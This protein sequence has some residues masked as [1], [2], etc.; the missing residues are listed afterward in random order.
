MRKQAA[1]FAFMVA[2]GFVSGVIAQ[3]SNCEFPQS[4][5]FDEFNYEGGQSLKAK[6]K[7]FTASFRQEVSAATAI[8]YVY[9][10]RSSKMTEISDLMEQIRKGLKVDPKDYSSRLSVVD[11]GY[12]VLPTVEIFIRPLPCSDWPRATS[13]VTVDEV[14]FS[15]F[16]LEKTMKLV[17]GELENLIISNPEIRCPPAARAVRSCIDG[18]QQEVFVVIDAKGVVSFS[19]AVGGHPL[20]RRSA[21]EFV[22][23]LRFTRTEVPGTATNLS[24]VIK[25]SFSDPES[26]LDSN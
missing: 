10:G 3:D 24:G 4:R 20:H 14:E 8:L 15:E 5:K 11:G 9:G 18:T 26:G 2:V 17:G 6:L 21:E 19:R 23:K 1:V 12:R 13:T 22:K 7:D 16:P 25:I